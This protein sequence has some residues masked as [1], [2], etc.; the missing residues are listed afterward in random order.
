MRIEV[1]QDEYNAAISESLEII[2]AQPQKSGTE[3][4]SVVLANVWDSTGVEGD[5]FEC[6]GIMD[7]TTRQIGLCLV[8][9]RTCYGRPANHPRFAEVEALYYCRARER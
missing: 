5:V 3:A 4:L 2:A 8:I 9:G 7:L 6:L 1:S